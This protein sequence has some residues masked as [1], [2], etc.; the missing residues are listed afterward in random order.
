MCGVPSW[1][2]ATDCLYRPLRP[3]YPRYIHAEGRIH[4]RKDTAQLREEIAR[5]YEEY[6][7]E[8]KDAGP[9]WERKPA[10]GGE[11]EEAWS[12]RQAAEH[13]ASSTTFFAN[14]IARA[15]EVDAPAI[16]QPAF[17]SAETAVASMPG[18]QQTL[19][20]VLDQVTDAQLDMEREFGPLGKSTLERVVG[21]CA[22]H[23]ND[24]GNQLRTLRL[25]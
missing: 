9:H 23:L 5:A 10:A 18:I 2:P 7:A 8:L 17:A 21:I 22:L 4:G 25:G 20:S 16:Q 13:I 15:V 6:L 14:G 11:G 24:H 3:H 12:A 19:Q 1:F